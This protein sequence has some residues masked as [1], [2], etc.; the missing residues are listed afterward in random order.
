[1]LKAGK[2]VPVGFNPIELNKRI[3]DIRMEKF[4]TEQIIRRLKGGVEVV[5]E[6]DIKDR[7]VKPRIKRD[8]SISGVFGLCVGIF[9]AFFLEYIGKAKR[10]HVTD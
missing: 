8:I 6:F 10:N 4:Q 9:S 2:L 7:P 5:K 3:S 1:L